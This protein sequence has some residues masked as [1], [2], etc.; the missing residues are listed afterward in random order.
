MIFDNVRAK[1]PVINVYFCRGRQG[2]C[3]MKYLNQNLFTLDRQSFR[4]NC[5]LFILF[6]QRGRVLKSIYQDFFN[7]NERR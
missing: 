2:N 4:E 7:N 3:N 5:N 6:E 1:E